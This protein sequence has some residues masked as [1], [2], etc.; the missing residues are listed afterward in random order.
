MRATCPA[1]SL[2]ASDLQVPSL[3]AVSV[4]SPPA[5]RGGAPLLR[6]PQDLRSGGSSSGRVR[7]A[8]PLQAAWRRLLGQQQVAQLLVRLGLRGAGLR[9]GRRG[10]ELDAHRGLGARRGLAWLGI[11]LGLGLGFG[12]GL[13]LELGLGIGLG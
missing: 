3:S 11:G 6:P 8:L 12:L 1:P 2:L 10:G 5:P 13:G 7:R 9:G 4:R